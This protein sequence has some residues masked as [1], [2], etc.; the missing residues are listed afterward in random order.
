MSVSAARTPQIGLRPGRSIIEALNVLRIL[1]G[2]DRSLMRNSKDRTRTGSKRR[3]EGDPYSA[4]AQLRALIESTHDLIWSVDREFRLISYNQALANHLKR[5]YGESVPLLGA[6]AQ[7]RLPPDRSALLSSLYARALAEG[8]FRIEY[9]VTGG[10]WVELSLNPIIENG[11]TT[12]ISAFGKDITEH[13]RA[14]LAVR[15][16]EARYHT[17]MQMSAQSFALL[18]LSDFT[19]V[20]VNDAFTE[21]HGYTP[22]EVLGRTPM[23]VGIF[24]DH[25]SLEAAREALTAR[26]EIRDREVRFRRKDG[27]LAWGLS[28]VKLIEIGGEQYIFSVTLDITWLKEAE[29]KIASLSFFDP[30]TGLPNRRQF[31]EQ[32]EKSRR[33]IK[34]TRGLEALLFVNLDNFSTVNDALGHSGGDRLLREAGDRLKAFARDKGFAARMSGDEFAFWITDLP[35][36]AEAAAETAFRV[37]TDLL[38]LLNRPYRID[39]QEFVNTSCIGISLFENRA[40]NVSDV[41]KRADMA[42]HEA[43]DAGRNTV[44]VFSPELAAKV[45]ARVAVEEELRLALAGNQF[46]LYYQPQI[47]CGRLVG[48]E[49][50]LRW[51]HPARG[52]LPPSE[53]ICVAER[54]GIILPIGEWVLEEACRQLA[55]WAGRGRSELSIAV[56]ISA[57]Q[58]QD[59]GFAGTVLRALSQAKADATRLCLE[60]TE[61]TLVEN[62]EEAAAKIRELRAQGVKFALDD[63]GT[64]Y[65]SLAYLRR[66]PIDYLKIDRSFVRDIDLET[67][68]TVLAEAITSLGGAMRIGVI[69]EGVETRLQ[70]V[71]L[72]RM[73][74]LMNQGYLYG[75][76]MPIEEFEARF[77]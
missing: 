56:N 38:K 74:C 9:Q 59:A 49:A 65:S 60:I 64:G 58:L 63:F 51:N 32:L 31:R 19:Y 17:M 10:Q 68:S 11:Q 28:S 7:D 61:S 3:V 20:E 70:E 35:A 73:G 55:R 66:L 23:E 16:S 52:V 46:S 50:L 54:T 48:A 57:L 2:H 18:R 72:A 36:D 77:L 40:A 43:K 44:R 76:P 15:E 27:N 22:G 33:E 75:M 62:T 6:K 14:E 47:D 71:L 12:G 42:L 1:R 53:F 69:A 45:R 13:R 41:M 34:E 24:D 29:E 30:L 39:G 67:G 5:E 4:S 37:G 26:G 25:R 21:F 8:P